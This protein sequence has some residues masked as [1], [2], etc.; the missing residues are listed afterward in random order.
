M[1]I[2]NFTRYFEWPEGSKAGTFTIHIL[3]ASNS[4]V[5][6]LND[7]VASKKTIGGQKVEVINTEKVDSKH[8]PQVLYITPDQYPQLKSIASKLKNKGVLVIAEK[9]GA[10]KAEAVIN[11]VVINN[12]QKFEFNKNN[13]TKYGLKTSEELKNQAS[14][15]Y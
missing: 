5:K 3:G 1:Y 6:E 10:A 4:L 14:A 13:A 8:A 11:F 7:N 12:K 9:D 15:V 2:Y